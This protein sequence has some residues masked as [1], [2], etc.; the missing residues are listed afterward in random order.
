MWY[1]CLIS[2]E[3]LVINHIAKEYKPPMSIPI[4]KK[5]LK[6]TQANSFTSR[7]KG[8]KRNME[9]GHTTL[10]I[11]VIAKASLL[12]TAQ[13]K[14][15]LKAVGNCRRQASL[16]LQR[17]SKQKRLNK[18]FSDENDDTG[19]YWVA[20]DDQVVHIHAT[21]RYYLFDPRVCAP[22]FQKFDREFWS[23]L[24]KV[25]TEHRPPSAP[26]MPVQAQPKPPPE[27]STAKK[28]TENGT[29]RFILP[30]VW[31]FAS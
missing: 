1:P 7:S 2:K 14:N 12:P 9:K 3:T 21:P 26:G 11:P 16:N 15:R 23:I 29:I 19:D 31:P 18:G 4:K 22:P 6:K 30:S 5:G 13:M 10:K 28:D 27:R 8:L 25:I 24:K 17:I 20:N